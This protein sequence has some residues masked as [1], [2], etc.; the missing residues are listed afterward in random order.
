MLTSS[1]GAAPIAQLRDAVCVLGTFPA[2]AG[3]N[4]T[5]KQ[6]EIVH[7]SGPNGAGKS[8][9]LR[10]LAG[11]VP[12]RSG[13]ATVMGFDVV[14]QRRAA[15]QHLALVGHDTFCYDDLTVGENLRFATAASGVNAIFADRAL[16]QMGLRPI[17]N[18][19]HSKLS[20]GQ[21]RRLALA[22]A[23][24][25]NAQLLLFDEPHAGLDAE[26]RELLDGI[27]AAAPD[28][29]KTVIFASHELDRARAIS[30]REVRVELGLI[31][32]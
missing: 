14:L 31:H 5:V 8:T 25:R 30:T 27:I 10:V 22:V 18:T 11:L 32:E 4:L 6:G 26:G 7:L 24:S 9:L 13:S 23:L 1:A 12:L 21:R 3:G 17:A 20:A 28:D 29:D 2:L 15:R 16:D 19:A